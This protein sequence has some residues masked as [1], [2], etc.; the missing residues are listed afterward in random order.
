MDRMSSAAVRLAALL[1]AAL[2]LGLVPAAA[3]APARS[4]LDVLPATPAYVTPE[5]RAEVALG[6]TPAILSWDRAVADHATVGAWLDSRGFEAQ[7]F[8]GV[9]A[10]AVCVG[11]PGEID[12]LSRAPGAISVWNDEPLIPT[13]D[14]TRQVAFNGNPDYVWKTL[15]ITGKGVGLAVVDTGI[16]GT[17]PDLAFPGKTKLNARVMV[18]H[19]E[20]MGGGDPPPCQDLYFPE[21]PDSEATSGHGTHMASIAAGTGAASDGRYSGIAPGADLIGVAATDTSSP[22]VFVEP[23][24]QGLSLMGGVA[25]MGYILS[26]ALEGPVIAKVALAGWT[27]E[28]LHDPYH[29]IYLAVKDLWAFGI[30][31]V[32]PTGNRGD[33]GEPDCSKAETCQF[34][35]YAL[36][37]YAIAVGAINGIS[38]NSLASWSSR[39]DSEER[40]YRGERFRYEPTLLAPGTAVVAARRVGTSSAP[41]AITGQLPG[42]RSAGGSA[43]TI[44]ADPHYQALSGTSVAAAHVAGTIALMQQ[45]QRDRTGC[46][47]TPT[48]VETILRASATH[49]PG[50]QSWEVGAGVLNATSAVLMAQSSPRMV[51]PDPWM[52]PDL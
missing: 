24:Q 28:G 20:Y 8:E 11:G 10:A 26:R 4:A 37:P 19:R 2:L 47:L 18:S 31:V 5:L 7:V 21:S 42:A 14:R 36:G 30:S 51:N 50:Y 6:S 1:A 22:H 13:L 45:A 46:F 48:Q 3:T 16:D 49:I 43:R 52:C 40:E 38:R 41:E 9:A 17:H 23:I 25:G 39:G 32:M 29:P 33:I 35:P 44:V 27:S 12:L 34:N 15:G